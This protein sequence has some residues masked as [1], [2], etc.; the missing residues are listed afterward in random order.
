VAL[1]LVLEKI[2]SS[3]WEWEATTHIMEWEETRC[4]YDRMC[5]FWTKLHVLEQSKQY[6]IK[7][8]WPSFD[9]EGWHWSMVTWRKWS[10]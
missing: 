4:I 8:I 1:P 7:Q 9:E 6:N 5:S 2:C 3:P 10:W